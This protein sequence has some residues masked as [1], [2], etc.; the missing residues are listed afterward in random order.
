M[1]GRAPIAVIPTPRSRWCGGEVFGLGD[2]V[3][4][5]RVLDRPLSQWRPPE[6]LVA[7]SSEGPRSG[8]LILWGEDLWV[9][10]KMLRV[11][12][13]AAR[14]VGG[15]RPVRLVR[16]VAGPAAASDPLGRLP[17]VNGG[18]AIGF[19]L[20]YIPEGV[21]APWPDPEGWP[22]ALEE[23]VGVDVA[24]RVHE[25]QIDVDPMVSPTGRMGIAFSD[26]AAAPVGHWAELTRTNLLAIGAQALEPGALRGALS[27]AWAALRAVSLNPHK[28]LARATRRGRGCWIHPSAVVEGCHLGDRVKVDACAVLRGCVVGDDVK[29]GALSIAEFS[30]IGRGAELQRQATA[31]LSVIYPGARIGGL[32]QLGVAGRGCRHKFGAIGTDMNPVGPVK[33][34][35]PDGLRVVDIGYQ[36][37]CLGHEAFIAAN[38]TIA[39]GRQIEAGRVVLSES[40]AIIRR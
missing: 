23:A 24:A 18:A 21:E 35:S 28:V 33:V 32:I 16:P 13:A 1:A 26:V 17:R 20:W 5:A 31:N 8:P 34:L 9:S 25:I 29:V 15:D 38:L 3:S 30:V 12:E 22:E 14:A 39:A 40:R 37:V 27:L 10:G 4:E 6:R 7:L 19:D 36:G 2:P 11:F